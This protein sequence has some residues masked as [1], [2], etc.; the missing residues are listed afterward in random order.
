M[1]L[2]FKILNF[3]LVSSVH[4][5]SEMLIVLF[6]CFMDWLFE[7]GAGVCDMMMGS[8]DLPGLC[9][10][11]GIVLAMGYLYRRSV[12]KDVA[13][14]YS[15]QRLPLFPCLFCFSIFSF[16]GFLLTN[17]CFTQFLG[18]DKDD[19]VRRSAVSG[20]KVLPPPFLIKV[21]SFLGWEN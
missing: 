21:L 14:L 17:F 13:A 6:A 3:N 15:F 1:S 9:F 2:V 8:T 5:M 20:K 16:I 10:W 18:R 4:Q 7:I 19:G 11:V 12:M